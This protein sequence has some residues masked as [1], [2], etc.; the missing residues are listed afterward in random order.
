M[1]TRDGA[2]LV[3]ASNRGGAARGDTNV[4]IADWQD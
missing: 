4:F 3:F 2:R 1:F